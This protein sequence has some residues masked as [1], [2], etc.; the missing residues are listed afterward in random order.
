ME[1]VNEIPAGTAQVGMTIRDGSQRLTITKVH[2]FVPFKGAKEFGRAQIGQIWI[3]V[4][5]AKGTER[6]GV[7]D[8]EQRIEVV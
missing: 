1:T 6:T 5:G 3:T 8:I 2:P 4:K 7:Y